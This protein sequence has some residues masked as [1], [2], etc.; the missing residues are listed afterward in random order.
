M[1]LP[2]WKEKKSGVVAVLPA[3]SRDTGRVVTCPE[4]DQKPIYTEKMRPGTQNI[5][6]TSAEV[7]GVIVIILSLLFLIMGFLN[8]LLLLKLET[9]EK[10]TSVDRMQEVVNAEEVYRVQQR[11]NQLTREVQD[12]SNY[13]KSSL[14]EISSRNQNIEIDYRTLLRNQ[15]APPTYSGGMTEKKQ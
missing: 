9:Q 7:Q 10:Q 3:A 13:I 2:L 1:Y 4:Q 14:A 5:L 6:K 11:V 8:G 12:L 15:E